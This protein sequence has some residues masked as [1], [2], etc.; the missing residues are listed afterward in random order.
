MSRVNRKD[1]LAGMIVGEEVIN[2]RGQLLIPAGKPIE[3]KHIRALKIWGIASVLIDEAD[4]VKS[5]T[6]TKNENPDLTDRKRIRDCVSRK[7]RWDHK[8]PIHPAMKQVI[9]ACI[10]RMERRGV[11]EDNAFALLSGKNGCDDTPSTGTEA[12]RVALTVPRLIS[13]VKEIVSLPDIY[14]KLMEVIDDPLSS[15]SDVADVISCDPGLT[16]RLLRIVNSAFYS[17]PSKIETVSQ[18]VTI[19]GTKELC[20]LALATSVMKMFDSALKGLMD[21]DLFWHHSIGCGVFARKLALFRHEPNAERFFV[22]GILHDIGRLILLS[23]TPRIIGEAM[24]AA[25]RTRNALYVL[26]KQMLGFTHTDVGT[27]LLKAWNLPA[28][29]QEAVATHHNPSKARRFKQEAATI[30]VADILA[31]AMGMGSSGNALVPDVVPEAW[32]QLEID[33]S[34]LIPMTEEAD[35]EV[36]DLLRIF[37]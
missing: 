18:G 11:P 36:S 15:A 9:T 6:V 16:A 21:M 30:H 26:E 23:H 29:H 7:F 17:F 10:L 3:E 1:L 4:D 32:E 2:N 37:K 14:Q 25:S 34:A 12:D 31:T 13:K 20:D 33:S 8:N 5:N 35:Y 27:A 19:L 28:S 22:M 24:L